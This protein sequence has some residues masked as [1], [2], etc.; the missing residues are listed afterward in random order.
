M[1][2]GTKTSAAAGFKDKNPSQD[3]AKIRFFDKLCF[4]SARGPQTCFT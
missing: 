1:L 3:I 4:Y 2:H